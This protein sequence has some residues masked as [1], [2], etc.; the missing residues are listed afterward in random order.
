[1]NR[2]KKNFVTAIVLLLMSICCFS[3]LGQSKDI[4][5]IMEQIRT[6]ISHKNIDDAITNTQSLKD[7]L[8]AKVVNILREYRTQ[9]DPRLLVEQ[10]AVSRLAEVVE[11]LLNTMQNVKANK[12][13]LTVDDYDY[14][15]DFV[16]NDQE[17][18]DT[19]KLH[20][21]Q[22]VF[23]DDDFLIWTAD[24]ST[25]IS[26]EGFTPDGLQWNGFEPVVRDTS[27]LRDA[28]KVIRSDSETIEI[29]AARGE[30]ETFQIAITPKV[31]DA[32]IRT[33]EV[34]DLKCGDNII[35]RENIT[36]NQVGYI[37]GRV[38]DKG[39]S[40]GLT[41]KPGEIMGPYP[42]VLF[43][44]PKWTTAEKG[45][46]FTIWFTVY[47]PYQS[48]SCQYQAKIR[49]L[50]DESEKLIPLN[51]NVYNFD[52]P[53]T[54][55]IN[56]N[57]FSLD[58]GSVC[59]YYMVAPWEPKAQQIFKSWEQLMVSH[60]FSPTCVPAY[61]RVNFEEF[62]VQS[63]GITDKALDF[64]D[65]FLLLSG[66]DDRLLEEGFTV[67][68]WLKINTIQNFNILR[69]EWLADFDTA[70]SSGRA[71]G[72]KI[73]FE[74][75]NI[76]TV[77][78]HDL[79]DKLSEADEKH[80]AEMN[81][82]RGNPYSEL[83]VPLEEPSRWSQI[84]ITYSPDQLIMYVDGKRTG[85]LK[86]ENP[87][88]L[89]RGIVV[90]GDNKSDFSLD[91]IK[92]FDSALS[93]SDVAANVNVSD[94]SIK[95]LLYYSFD[96]PSFNFQK[97]ISNTDSAQ[98]DDDYMFASIKWWLDRGLY[99][100][101]P[102]PFMFAGS[103]KIAS[104]AEKYYP[105]LKELGA[106]D[107]C[108]VF[109]PHD[110]SPFGP[111]AEENKRFADAIHKNMPNVKCLL[112]LGGMK[113]S[114]STQQ[115]KADAVSSYNGYADAWSM[116]PSIYDMFY[117]SHFVEYQANG[118][119]ISPY[120]HRTD[121][122]QND[123]TL[124][125]GRRFFWYLWAKDIDMFTLWNTNL[126]VQPSRL[127]GMRAGKE[128][129]PRENG[130]LTTKRNNGVCDGTMF[131]PG[132]N[133][134]L[135]SIRASNWREGIEDYGYLKLLE[136]A[137]KKAKANGVTDDALAEAQKMLSDMRKVKVYGINWE[138]PPTK[139]TAFFYENREKIARLIEELN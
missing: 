48:K 29:S 72:Y 40:W 121:V 53:K 24:G 73:S 97:N 93:D 114:S 14:L 137:V 26:N 98:L 102:K 11:P 127:G 138:K 50:I 136:D 57:L 47:V 49:L 31:N 22:I 125:A 105:K 66:P 64:K 92:W 79:V 85:E 27:R 7:I 119:K 134:M 37:W 15:I 10:A 139:D 96:E 108:V 106:L 133:G 82:R 115:E 46:N 90:C 6:D 76:K 130:F 129:I 91:E 54:A 4:D 9:K 131:Y 16:N 110:E 20:D 126:W 116:I 81:L 60:R 89:S 1:M 63:D 38:S 70:S 18:A 62:P 100:N 75:G 25:R 39:D 30:Y 132:E 61:P 45:E 41:L 8:N 104:L 33:I 118:S 109:L 51:L 87:M 28:M 117:K 111:L 52:L 94:D 113:G 74:N 78:G 135:G 68:F 77:I 35:S 58:I 2:I 128:F 17:N 69:Q 56:T 123:N 21:N 120:I 42:D 32:Q 86:L 13:N 107:K 5:I 43:P 55:Q 103:S 112:T 65:R 84:A 95:A 59:S 44:F 12:A 3:V 101:T 36:I 67:S 83:T 88:A 99:I 71:C 19:V 122:L 124:A 23:A 34:S 80:L